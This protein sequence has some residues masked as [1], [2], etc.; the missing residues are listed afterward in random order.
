VRHLS[1]GEYGHL[2]V[3]TCPVASIRMH[4]LTTL[5]LRPAVTARLPFMKRRPSFSGPDGYCSL[6]G[7]AAFVRQARHSG[8]S[9]TSFWSVVKL[10][11]DSVAV[12]RNILVIVITTNTRRPHESI[13]RA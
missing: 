9:A 1:C 7:P 6:I 3:Q 10:R 13:A 2:T 12:R 5:T 11:H 4:M 8:S